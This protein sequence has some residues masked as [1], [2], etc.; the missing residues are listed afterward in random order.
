[1]TAPGG[2][3]CKGCGAPIEWV[4]TT[5]GKKMPVDPEPITVVLQ[6]G[7][8]V[9]GAEAFRVV[10]GRQSHFA[11]CP[12]ADAFRKRRR[13][14]ASGLGRQCDNCDAWVNPRQRGAVY[15]GEHSYCND[16]CRRQRMFE[17]NGNEIA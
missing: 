11:S 13:P 8:A 6:V 10:T 7:K 3:T 15:V 2:S 9:E 12:N 5:G 14:D 1:M 4:L 16:E 17:L